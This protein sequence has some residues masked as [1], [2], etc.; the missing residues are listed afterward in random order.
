MLFC[1]LLNQL[2]RKLQ[3]G[4]QSKNQTY[5]CERSG[6]VVEYLTGDRG[7]AGMSLTGVTVLCPLAR[8]SNLS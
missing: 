8:H 3:S 4:I 6:S 2:Y 7:A 1:S 5:L